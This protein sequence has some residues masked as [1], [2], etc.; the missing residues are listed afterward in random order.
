[1]LMLKEVASGFEHIYVFVDALDECPKSNREREKLL[2]ALHEICGWKMSSL[3]ILTTSRR[4]A[5]IQASFNRSPM[6]LGYFKSIGVEG[7][8]V[9]QDIRKYLQQRLQNHVFEKWGSALKE[10]V[11]FKLASQA[12]GM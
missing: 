7:A 1:M 8:H 5:D 2:N 9:E 11:E 10:D 4:E 3:H 6:D 12:N